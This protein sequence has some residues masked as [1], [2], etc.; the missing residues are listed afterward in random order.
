MSRDGP[1]LKAKSKKRH[2]DERSRNVKIPEQNTLFLTCCYCLNVALKD[3][4]V[5]SHTA[6]RSQTLKMSQVFL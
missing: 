3:E 2:A 1:N 5:V 6:K 4:H